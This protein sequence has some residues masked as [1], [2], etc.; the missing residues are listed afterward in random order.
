VLMEDRYLD[1]P[2]SQDLDPVRSRSH[3]CAG[4]Q[5]GQRLL[6]FPLA[7]LIFGG[8]FCAAG[9]FI[10]AMTDAT[11]T[12]WIRGPA[13]VDN[14]EDEHND[15][16]RRACSE[17]DAFSELYLRHYRDVFHYCIR[18]LFDRHLAEDVTSTVF[19][20]VLHGLHSFDGG[21]AGF[22][23]WLLR[24]ATNAVNDHLREARRRSDAMERIAE[25]C[26]TESIS[27]PVPADDLAE[28]R[29]RLQQALLSLKPK[30]QAVITLRFFENMKLDEVAACLGEKPSTVR[31]WLSRAT[32]KLRKKLTVGDNRGPRP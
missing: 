19:F 2:W 25:N 24:I 18:R 5:Q 28:R 16:I 3:P 6:R 9:A 14:R 30:Y 17:P 29:A 15:L 8:T 11:C 10:M 21:A 23:G 26:R 13:G 4:C 7:Y 27:P 22:R 32:A 1:L 31:T 20:K 12:T